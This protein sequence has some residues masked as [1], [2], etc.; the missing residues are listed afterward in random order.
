MKLFRVIL[1]E[2]AMG[3]TNEQTYDS[4]LTTMLNR[5]PAYIVP[6]INEVFGEH[7]SSKAE[8]AFKINKHVTQRT[9]G[10]LRR[11][12]SDAY[13]ELSEM[14]QELVRKFYHFE[15]EAWY[16]RSI[17]IRI[18]EYGSVI[19][20][21]NAEITE[22]GVVLN[23]PN[24]AVIVLH[25]AGEIPR[26]MRITHR[27]PNGEEMSYKVPTLQIRDYSVEEI[28]RKKL[29]IL[30]SFYLFRYANEFAKINTDE[31]RQKELEEVVKD[32]NIRLEDLAVRVTLNNYEK[33]LIQDLL[34]R[35]SDKLLKNYQKIREG[36]DSIMSGYI[37]RTAADD[38]LEQGIEKGQE[39]T[40]KLMNFLWENGLGNEARRAAN[41]NNYLRELLRKYD[42]GTLTV[43]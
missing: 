7:F 17:V 10:S 43:Q 4:A 9:D 23:Y 18:A 15:C 19:A 35:V 3:L 6:L 11:V 33:T 25:P 40:S 5:L 28:F 41:D 26:M 13:I 22:D 16:D 31:T 2:E 32:I 39:Q 24:A 30:L 36:V 34:Q 20:I 37:L 42:D 12:E 21:E 27:G 1:R 8:V 14:M 29:L 38:I